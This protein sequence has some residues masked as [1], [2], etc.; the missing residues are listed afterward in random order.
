[1]KLDLSLKYL[2]QIKDFKFNKIL[3]E[4]FSSKQQKYKFKVLAQKFSFKENKVI[5]SFLV[6]NIC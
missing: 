3:P 4:N 1:M 5:L 2:E 6:I